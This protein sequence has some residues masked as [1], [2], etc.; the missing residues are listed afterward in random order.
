MGCIVGNGIMKEV[1]KLKLVR[2]NKV[3]LRNHIEAEIHEG[4]EAAAKLDDEISELDR[5]I[6]EYEL[7]VYHEFS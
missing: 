4:I 2:S 7:E 3:A 5:K 6:N 1:Q